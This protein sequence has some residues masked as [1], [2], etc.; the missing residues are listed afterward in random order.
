M[1]FLEL[2]QKATIEEG[3]KTTGIEA[4]LNLMLELEK[5]LC[6]DDEKA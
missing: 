3:L 2:R 1:A 4:M 6:R 5:K